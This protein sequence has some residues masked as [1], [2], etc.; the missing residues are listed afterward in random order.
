M[1]NKNIKEKINNNNSK[2]K[3]KFPDVKSEGILQINE[4]SN[5]K[6]LKKKPHGFYPKMSSEELIECAKSYCREHKITKRTALA[7]KN[8]TLYNELCKRKLV[9][10]I[11]DPIKTKPR[12]FYSKMNDGELILFAKKYCE[13]NKILTR[14]KLNNTYSGLY[15]VLKKRGLFDSVGLNKTLGDWISMSDKE[16]IE[17]SKGEK[18]YVENQKNYIMCYIGE[19]FL[20]LFSLDNLTWMI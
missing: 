17:Y 18:N 9:D 2:S 16:L 20:I 8:K 1:M 15:F 3:V 10:L 5:E 19:N 6:D 4:K 7:K 13:E 14:T 12:D 11:F